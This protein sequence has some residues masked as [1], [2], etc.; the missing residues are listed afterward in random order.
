MTTTQNLTSAC[1]FPETN[2]PIHWSLDDPYNPE[3]GLWCQNSGGHTPAT[4]ALTHTHA[5]PD[6]ATRI[7]LAAQLDQ[8]DTFPL[9]EVL[10][11]LAR[12]QD[13]APESPTFGCFRWY[14]EDTHCH[15]TNAA[16]FV[17]LNLLV[18][19]AGYRRQLGSSECGLLDKMFVG[20]DHWFDRSVQHAQFF[21]PNKFLG[22]LVC[23]WLLKEH[24]GT[25]G[26]ACELKTAMAKSADYWAQSPWGWGEHLS[27]LYAT[28][29]LDELSALLL[30]AHRLPEALRKA[31]QQLFENLLEIEDAYDGGPRVPAIRSYAFNAAI[32]H[33][34]YRASIRPWKTASEALHNHMQVAHLFRSCFGKIFYESKWHE[35]A[36]PCPPARKNITLPCFDGAVARAWRDDRFRVG[37]LSRYP[38]MADTD[39]PTWGLSWQTFPLAFTQGTSNWGFWRWHTREEGKDKFHPACDKHQAILNNALSETMSPVPVGETFSH[40]EGASFCAL[41]RMP[42]LSRQWEFLSDGLDLTSFRG[43][44]IEE[45]LVPGGVS[46]LVLQLADGPKIAIHHFG[47]GHASAPELTRGAGS[48]HW[49]VTWLPEDFADPHGLCAL[50]TFSS[51]VWDVPEFRPASGKNQRAWHLHWPGLA[52]ASATGPASP[53]QPNRSPI[54]TSARL[55]L[56]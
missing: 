18:L 31:C 17:G 16:F 10:Q 27:D 55:W 44:V 6:A 40:Q 22:D 45:S 39:E 29:M 24:L 48:L 5:C 47:A 33:R 30:F 20:L 21:Y 19:N 28:I 54:S 1:K 34:N 8:L 13:N 11:G 50:W 52:S 38:I 12:M 41:R 23:S 7:V 43:E 3:L 53:A 14:A 2:E 32:D 26:A 46:R 49:R 56:T 25:E 35:L 15:D 36:P 51:A 42:R 9:R 37:S 4:S